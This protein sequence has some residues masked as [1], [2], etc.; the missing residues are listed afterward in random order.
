[1]TRLPDCAGRTCEY[2][3]LTPSEITAKAYCYTDPKSGETIKETELS[4]D[5]KTA[6]RE[7]VEKLYRS[8]GKG[9]GCGCNCERTGTK[10]RGPTIP[11]APEK[12]THVFAGGGKVEGT[13]KVSMTVFEGLC[14]PD[15]TGP[16]TDCCC[17]RHEPP[18][19]AGRWDECGYYY[20]RGYRYPAY[21]PYWRWPRWY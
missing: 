19:H 16:A 1:M 13:F 4:E 7:A 8:S 10:L 3:E 14:V 2:I 5:V 6:F 12:Y 21:W 9:C 15:R 17:D 11:S 20:H 18:R